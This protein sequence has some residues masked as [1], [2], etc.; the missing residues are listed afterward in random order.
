MGSSLVSIF[1]RIRAS[2]L[3]RYAWDMAATIGGTC[4]LLMTVFPGVPLA[5][6]GRTPSSL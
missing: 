3:E 2:V 4:N 6:E 1:L 5:L